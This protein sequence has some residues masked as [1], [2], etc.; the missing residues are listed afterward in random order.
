M[1][2]TISTAFFPLLRLA[3]AIGAVALFGGCQPIDAALDCNTICKRY[4]DC[5]NGSYDVSAC[6]DRCRASARTNKDLANSINRC[7]ACINDR[8]CASATFNC[9]ADCSNIVP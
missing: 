1:S 9:G 4:K 3:A 6:A 7:E 2:S 8:A 5:Y